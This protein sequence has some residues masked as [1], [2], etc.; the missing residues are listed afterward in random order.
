MASE[1][2]S[3]VGGG[4][5]L[6]EVMPSL[7][8]GKTGSL[9]ADPWM[10]AVV[11]EIES[12]TYGIGES[13][14]VKPKQLKKFGRTNKTQSG[15][16]VSIMTLQGSEAHETILTIN[17]VDYVVS[18]STSDNGK[19]LIYEYFTIDET[20]GV[21][22]FNVGEVTLLGQTP[23]ALPV[24]A[25]TVTR[26][27]RKKGT[28]ASPATNLVGNIAF[29]ASSGVT[30]T[31]GVVQTDSAVKLLLSAGKQ[32]SEKCASAISQIDAY[33][34]T[35][36]IFSMEKSSGG[37]GSTARIN[38]D[39]EYRELGGVWRPLGLNI[40]LSPNLPTVPL[41]PIGPY[42]WI[43]PNTDFRAT[44]F[45]DTANVTVNGAIWG[46]LLQVDS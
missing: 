25:N 20:T 43:G 27:Y 11:E 35:N 13:V 18:S 36:G 26:A 33:V 2:P 19:A 39:V 8:A 40:E 10:Q 12:S 21:K 28:F 14:S 46:Q 42:S 15:A 29:Y 1:L 37:G 16:S 17:A 6:I 44:A 4:D 5:R 3:V 34:I 45:S 22:T 7:I 32:Q 38:V 9:T 23:A 41:P 24:A 31:A 30:V